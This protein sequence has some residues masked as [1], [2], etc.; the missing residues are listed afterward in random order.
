MSIHL[1]LNQGET[2]ALIGPNGAGKTTFLLTLALLHQPTSGTIELDGVTAGPNNLLRFSRRRI[3]RCFQEA[4]DSVIFV[5]HV[6]VGI[7]LEE[8]P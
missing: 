5:C 7:E 4:F 8:S 6:A 3:V 2:I 1:L